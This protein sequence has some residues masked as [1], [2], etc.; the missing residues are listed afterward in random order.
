MHRYTVFLR[1]ALLLILLDVCTPFSASPTKRNSF[2]LRASPDPFEGARAGVPGEDVNRWLVQKGFEFDSFRRRFDF[3][4]TWVRDA[5]QS[6]G[7]IEYL[8]AHGL[9][10]DEAQQQSERPY[11]QSFERERVTADGIIF[12]VIIDGGRR[13]TTYE[14]GEWEETVPTNFNSAIFE[15]GSQLKRRTYWKGANHITETTTADGF[16]DTTTRYLTESDLV[17]ERAYE[18]SSEERISCKEFFVRRFASDP[19]EVLTSSLQRVP[20]CVANVDVRTTLVDYDNEYRL[21]L[22]GEADAMISRGILAVLSQVVEQM[23]AH[24]LLSLEPSKVA[25]RLGLRHA[26][27]TGR[28]DGLASITKT[29]QSQI[30]AILG[31]EEK[32]GPSDELSVPTS[33][34]PTV[35]VLLSGGVDS[36][37][38]LNLLKRQGYDV[39]AFYLKIWLEDEL[40]HLGKCPWEDDY[41]MCEAICAQADVPLEAI[42]LQKEYKD[43][44]I[45]YT[46]TEADRGRTPNPDIM[47]NSRVKFGCFYDAIEGR[48]FDYVASGHYAQL[49]LD[50]ETG[51]KKLL[52]APDPVKDQSY[53]LCAL[54]QQQLKKVLFPI[55]HLQKAEV[56][57]LAEDFDLPNKNRPDSQGLCFLGKVK[58]D[59]FLGAYLADRPGDI[60]DA[61]TGEVLGKH[62]GVWY[63]TVGQRKGIGKVLNPKATSR[64]PWYVVSK[65]PASDIV[66]A[67]NEYDEDIFTAA[68]TN[69][70]IED[71]HWI[72][73]K[74]PSELVDEC[75]SFRPG[76][77]HMKIRHG[78]R[79]VE[80]SLLLTMADAGNVALDNKDG[81]LAPGQFVVFYEVNGIECLGGGVISER[82]WA[83]FL[84]DRTEADAPAAL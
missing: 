81:G 56:R 49:V 50:E 3:G 18:K 21:K 4:G 63:H 45:S 31:R 33:T 7:V 27:S 17:V 65:D 36:S 38:A 2:A 58:F 48:G 66:Y 16:V 77:F 76:R 19:S 64:G 22:D 25:D 6:V 60:I 74:P 83:Q 34:K 79:I 59:E 75:G 5:T 51:L 62:K 11:T 24:E 72:N 20:G 73:G 53:F 84:L 80:G 10:R 32:E 26:L 52:R 30:K 41:L 37:V 55:G 35:A 69:V 9:T 78:P 42:S 12:R 71:I 47:C 61:A 57:Q 1:A 82:H 14:L 13:N 70:F 15:D 23:S 43:S 54:T 28:N 46:V 40:A 8:Q 68:R 29:V 67:S 39:T 44:V